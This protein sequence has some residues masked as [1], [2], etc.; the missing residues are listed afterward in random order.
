MSLQDLF[1]KQNTNSKVASAD[2]ATSSAEYVES[3][4]TINTIHDGYGEPSTPE[5][6]STKGGPHTGSSAFANQ[7]I[8]KA[9][10]GSNYYNAADDL[11]SS[12]E[13]NFD[14]GVTVEFWLKKQSPLHP[15]Q[16]LVLTLFLLPHNPEPQVSLSTSQRS[17]TSQLLLSQTAI[18]TTMP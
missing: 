15:V 6:I 11:G 5:Y 16:P 18:G 3:V 17:R 14:P 13:L 7:S 2:N 10:S 8:Y 12:L 1:K 9:F 4:A